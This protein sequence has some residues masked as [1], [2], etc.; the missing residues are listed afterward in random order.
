MLKNDHM[1]SAPGFTG[2]SRLLLLCLTAA[3]LA[4][5]AG[6]HLDMDDQPK[7]KPL[8]ASDFYPDGS[9]A[10]MPVD[11]TIAHGH[12]RTDELLYTGKINGKLA[13]LFPYPVTREVIDRGHD[14]FD[15][16][17][18]PC[19]GR[20]ANGQ[21]MIVKRGFPAP[22]SLLADS[23]KGN[24]AGFF[25]DVMTA[26]FGRMYSYAPSVPVK[27]RWAIVAYLR[28]L[29]LSQKVPVTALS[30]SDRAILARESR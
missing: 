28:A 26:G 10:R 19:H 17:C 21:G 11:S 22:P 3:G 23:I 5:V 4:A 14:R 9:S 27:D 1:R 13:D 20:L 24:P 7:Y 8:A 25:F 18:S 16:F 6:C 2:V 12:L 29:Q 30:D 15:T